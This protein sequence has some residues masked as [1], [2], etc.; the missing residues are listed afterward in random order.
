MER[1]PYPSDL[2]DE[3]WKIIEPYIPPERW[4]GRTRSVDM[5]EV[6]NGIG[7]LLRNGCAWRAI[8]HDLPNWGTCRH[9][10][11]RFRADG[12]WLLIHERLRDRVREDAG[13]NP[14]PAAAVVDAQVVRTTEKGG[15]AGTTRASGRR[16][17]SGT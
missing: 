1:K 17:A 3:Q 16:A 12:T 7:Y 15:S 11:D 10:Y 5:R 8:P 6:I 13:R 9:Y 4:G 2:T 14:E